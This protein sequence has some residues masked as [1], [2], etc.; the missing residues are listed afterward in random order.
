MSLDAPNPEFTSINNGVL[1]CKDCS[2]IH[3]N[4]GEQFS[5]LKS[6]SDT[7]WKYPTYL[8]LKL[9]GNANFNGFLVPYKLDHENAPLKYKSNAAQFYRRRVVMPLTSS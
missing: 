7:D 5:I 2:N 8:Y 4:L 9:G 6:L 1:L 3:K